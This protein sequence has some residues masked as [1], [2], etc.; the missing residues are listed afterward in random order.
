MLKVEKRNLYKIND[1]ENITMFPKIRFA[2]NFFSIF[3]T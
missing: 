1:C 3:Y 2:I